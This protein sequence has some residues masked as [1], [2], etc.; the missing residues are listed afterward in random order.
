MNL[1]WVVPAKHSCQCLAMMEPHASGLPMGD[2]KEMGISLNQWKSVRRHATLAIKNILRMGT[3]EERFQG[4]LLMEHP[5]SSS[6]M[7]GAKGVQIK[8]SLN[9]RRS[10][11][12]DAL[13]E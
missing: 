6:T 4:L 3:V 13:N 11:K 8:I 9:Q 1:L 12:R 2:A 5:V 7:G 10:V